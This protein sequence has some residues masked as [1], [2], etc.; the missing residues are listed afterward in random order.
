M[1]QGGAV[2]CSVDVKD[3]YS[4]KNP[5]RGYVKYCSVLHSVAGCCRAV[6]GVAGWCVVLQRRR[7]RHVLTEK[8][9]L[10]RCTGLLCV[11][12]VFAGCCRVLQSV[13]GCC[14]LV[15]CVAV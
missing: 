5:T 1:L 9:D 13:A 15:R 2:C 7:C 14:R 6:Q 3:T 4:Q 8:S 12:R 11:C 10:R